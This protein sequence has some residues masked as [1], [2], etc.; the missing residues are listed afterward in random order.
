MQLINESK[1][2]IISYFTQTSYPRVSNSRDKR[3]KIIDELKGP[4][5]KSYFAKG[6]TS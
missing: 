6:V 5:A 3:L 4:V 2:R 1:S